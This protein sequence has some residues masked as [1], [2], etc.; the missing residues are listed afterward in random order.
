MSVAILRAGIIDTNQHTCVRVFACVDVCAPCMYVPAVCR[1]QKKAMDPLKM[2]SQVVVRC[3]VCS[4]RQT[5][6]L[7]KS[8]QYSFWALRVFVNILNCFTRFVLLCFSF[9]FIPSC[10][11][12]SVSLI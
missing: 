8:N 4:R 5:Q 7:C 9:S 3:Y 6:V 11:V 12:L 2:E 10:G 1:G